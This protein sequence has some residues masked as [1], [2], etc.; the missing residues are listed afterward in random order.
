M[1]HLASDTYQVHI[2]E[3]ETSVFPE[4]RNAALIFTTFIIFSLVSPFI[5]SFFP[6][7]ILTITSAVQWAA[8]CIFLPPVSLT[9]L[10]QTHAGSTLGL[11]FRPGYVEGLPCLGSSGTPWEGTRKKRGTA[12]KCYTHSTRRTE[13]RQGTFL[14]TILEMTEIKCFVVRRCANLAQASGCRYLQFGLNGIYLVLLHLY[15]EGSVCGSCSYPL[16]LPALLGLSFLV[17][18][19]PALLVKAT[20]LRI[21]ECIW[22]GCFSHPIELN[23]SSPNSILMSQY[24]MQA[25]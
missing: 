17:P 16:Y 8:R 20:L 19:D 3:R 9:Q 15:Q 25:K 24:F 12:C 5:P 18:Q 21:K 22:S 6:P 4:G 11:V 13:Q 14:G 2:W 10:E 1:A 7:V 23:F